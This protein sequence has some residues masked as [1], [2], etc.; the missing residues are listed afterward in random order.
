M[1]KRNFRETIRRMFLRYAFFPISLLFVLFLLFTMISS[2]W[3]TVGQTQ[4]AAQ[5]IRSQLEDVF[6]S[7]DQEIR[8]MASLD[9][10]IQYV[11]HNAHSEL[12][13][14]QFYQFNNEQQVKSLM[15]ILD[16][17]GMILASSAVDTSEENERTLKEI[18][19]RL[20]R[21]DADVI[22]EANRLRH[23]LDRFTSYTFATKVRNNQGQIEGYL[24]YQLNEE[25]LERLIFTEN[26]EIAIVTDQHQSIIATTSNMVRGLMNKLTMEHTGDQATLKDASYYMYQTMIEN[27][28]WHI[29]TL[30]AL[31]N[32]NDVYVFLTI[33]FAMS[34]FL[35][36]FLI[37][38]LAKRIASLHT[39]NVD[40][41]IVAVK[42]LQEGNMHAY[43]HITSGD[44][45]ETLGNQFNQMLRSLNELRE[46]NEELSSLRR[47][48]EVKHLQAQFHPHV[49]FNILETLRYAI[50]VDQKMAQ[51][52]ILILSRLLRYSINTDQTTEV[53]MDDIRYVEDY[54]RLHQMRFKD[55][56]TYSIH[57]SAEAKQAFVP[58]LMTQIAIENAIKYGYRNKD[59]LHITVTGCVEQSDLIVTVEDNGGG[60]SEERLQEV[61]RLMYDADNRTEHIGLNNLNWRLYL[62][63]GQS[64]GVQIDSK[65]GEGTQVRMTIPYRRGDE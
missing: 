56:L 4:D 36:W 30:N 11:S 5:A 51:E 53:L 21:F 19:M 28:P 50:V 65:L 12:V 48:A 25:D 46:K 24:I 1:M 16:E 14:E 42:E 41:L 63:Y 61:R 33:F 26:N 18:M 37:Q 17:D 13:F 8:R 39:R 44:E 47:V 55:R 54:L 7:Y 20:S 2:R 64:Y 23:S 29:Y 31:D 22:H 62:L 57:V 38:F 15:Y 3:M 59:R 10:V 43:V 6:H 40:K 45:F 27:G 9:S 35:M 32:K 58:R 34:S 52:I 60:M 49:I